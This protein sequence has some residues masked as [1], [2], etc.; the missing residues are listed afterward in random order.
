MYDV[1]GEG[2]PRHTLMLGKGRSL[3]HKERPRIKASLVQFLNDYN[4]PDNPVTKDW[5]TPS[6]G[7]PHLPN[8]D[9]LDR[10]LAVKSS[11]EGKGVLVFDRAE[12]NEVNLTGTDYGRTRKRVNCFVGIEYHPDVLMAMVVQFIKVTHPG[13]NPGPPLRLAICNFYNEASAEHLGGRGGGRGRG[14]QAAA[15]GRGRGR[16]RGRGLPQQAQHRPLHLLSIDMSKISYGAGG[17]K[18]EYYAVDTATIGHKLV[19][20]FN[21]PNNVYGVRYTNLTSRN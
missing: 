20:A 11:K 17:N 16:G 10:V 12:V 5:L 19:V 6:V 21:G 1:L 2:A 15:G 8:L 14:G 3:K 9:L 7:G 4:D 18:E 13:P